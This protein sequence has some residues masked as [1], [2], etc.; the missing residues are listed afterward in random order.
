M[1]PQD[2]RRPGGEMKWEGVRTSSW[3]KVRRYGIR[4]SQRVD[5]D[6][7]NNWTKRDFKNK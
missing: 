6:G 3:R 7:N 5:Q 2:V 4:N 1:K